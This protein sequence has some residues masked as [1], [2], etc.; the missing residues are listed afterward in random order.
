M[1]L[2]SKAPFYKGLKNPLAQWVVL[3][4]A[5]EA[6]AELGIPISKSLHNSKTSESFLPVEKKE[7]GV[8]QVTEQ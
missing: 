8:E 4:A 1:L 5:E 7:D 6:I 2:D 3:N